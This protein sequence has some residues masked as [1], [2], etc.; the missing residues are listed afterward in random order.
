MHF[1]SG[2]RPRLETSVTDSRLLPR[3]RGES[4]LHK[5]SCFAFGPQRIF[6]FSRLLVIV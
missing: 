2:R 6:T 1:P 5:P 4:T 3:T